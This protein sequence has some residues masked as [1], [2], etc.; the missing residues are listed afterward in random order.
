MCLS[1]TRDTLCWGP[2][3]IS[4]EHGAS[5][6]CDVL[7]CVLTRVGGSPDEARRQME[8]NYFGPLFLIQALL[9]GMRNRASGIIVNVSS[10]AGIDGLPS[11]G[12]YASS[13][14]ALEGGYHGPLV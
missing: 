7:V 5:V 4:G 11:C 1:T 8:T 10:V 2:S 3:R 12:L 14:F 13:K 6:A 9:P